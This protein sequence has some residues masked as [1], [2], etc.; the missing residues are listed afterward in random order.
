[1]GVKRPCDVRLLYK[2]EMQGEKYKDSYLLYESAQNE[3][4]RLEEKA[5]RPKKDTKT[6]QIYG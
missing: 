3:L 1:M 4:K 6:D 2:K 5:N